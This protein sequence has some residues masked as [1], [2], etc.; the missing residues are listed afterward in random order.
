MATSPSR[1][2]GLATAG[3][4][5]P[6]P[7]RRLTAPARRI[8]LE[9]AE[10]LLGPLVRGRHGPA[11]PGAGGRGWA[12]PGGSAAVTAEPQDP[13]PL[14]P[15]HPPLPAATNPSG[16]PP[17]R[18]PI[19]GCRSLLAPPPGGGMTA[20]LT[21]QT[22]LS[23][24]QGR[25]RSGRRDCS[26]GPDVAAMEAPQEDRAGAAGAPRALEASAGSRAGG[27]KLPRAWSSPPGRRRTSPSRWSSA[28][29]S[30]QA[31][32]GP[33]V[34][35]LGMLGG[36]PALTSGGAGDAGAQTLSGFCWRPLEPSWT[37][38]CVICSR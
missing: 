23:L 37:G 28:G 21:N 38:S 8:Q 15:A 24:I 31:V 34:S 33:K 20:P 27:E 5:S 1:P 16:R 9:A 14:P 30:R 18:Q 2:R 6:R 29:A 7:P 22:A 19:N 4:R 36:A 12:G 13:P 32:R 25:V 17:P 26:V 10:D 35:C 3:R 11:P